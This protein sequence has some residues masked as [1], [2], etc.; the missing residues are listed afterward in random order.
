MVST[1]DRARMTET[2]KSICVS[3]P[4]PRLPASHQKKIAGVRCTL[5]KGWKHLQ[6]PMRSAERRTRYNSQ[7]KLRWGVVRMPPGFNEQFTNM[8]GLRVGHLTFGAE[9]QYVS[10]PVEDRMQLYA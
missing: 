4:H 6:T 5:T 1:Q 10:Q 7:S 2:T 9:D 3:C 8:D